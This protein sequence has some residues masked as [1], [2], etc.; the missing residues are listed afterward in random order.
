[1]ESL[2]PNINSFEANS[3][4]FGYFVQHTSPLNRHYW[5]FVI[6]PSGQLQAEGVAKLRS[7]AL[8]SIVLKL[9]T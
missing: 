4:N 8:A 6:S 7:E 1:M 5:Y 2:G 3:M 9:L